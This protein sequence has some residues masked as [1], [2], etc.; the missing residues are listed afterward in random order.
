MILKKSVEVKKGETSDGPSPNLAKKMSDY[1]QLLAAQGSLTT[2]VNY[3]NNSQDVS[4][5]VYLLFFCHS[6]PLGLSFRVR[7]S[8]CVLQKHKKKMKDSGC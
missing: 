5:L 4:Y 1:A 3:L 2:A 8:F 7:L 6:F